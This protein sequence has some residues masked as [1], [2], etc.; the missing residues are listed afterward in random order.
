MNTTTDKIYVLIES[1]GTYD[2]YC[3]TPIG[4]TYTKAEASRQVKK[5]REMHNIKHPLSVYKDDY[6][7]YNYYRNTINDVLYDF[8]EQYD[9]KFSDAN[10][11]II[12]KYKSI[13]QADKTK[14]SERNIELKH[15]EEEYF[16]W[17]VKFFSECDNEHLQEIIKNLHMSWE[18]YWR[19]SDAYDD[20]QSKEF[21]EVYFEEIH[22]LK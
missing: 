21:N 4:F 1:T 11:E 10:D 9:D 20:E 15:L 19:K 17:K 18:E 16:N 12:T 5:I 3:N 14:V 7:T 8:E 22:L 2:T 6:E 13:I